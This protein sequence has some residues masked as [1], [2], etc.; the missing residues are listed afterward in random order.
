LRIRVKT[1]D[2]GAQARATG[3]TINHLNPTCYSG[4][5]P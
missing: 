5:C 4:S 2:D 3:R 1:Q